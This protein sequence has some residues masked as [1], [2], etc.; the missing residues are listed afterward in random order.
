MATSM[1][2]LFNFGRPLPEP[3]EKLPNKKV[4]GTASKY[5]AW[6][7]PSAPLS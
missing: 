5:G 6:K 4:K 3:F 7:P 1:T 2:N